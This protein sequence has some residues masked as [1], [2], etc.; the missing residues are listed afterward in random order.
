MGLRTYR[1]KRRFDVTPE[2]E[3]RQPGT[4]R[5]HAFVI[6]KH[7][8]SRLHYDFRLEMDGVLKSWAVPKGPSLDP[9][10]KRLAVEVED[11][12]LEYGAFEGAIPN[13]QYGAGEVIVWDR[14]TWHSEGDESAGYKK[15]HLRFTLEGSKLRG[16]WNLVRIGSLKGRGA[17]WLLVKERD[18]ESRRER[19][20]DIL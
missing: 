8:A 16:A 17:N 12:P 11:H 20:G 7:D 13:G 4:R 9:S 2:P 10:R 19:E 6:Q 18:A 15:G 1:S 3:G 14:G 5:R